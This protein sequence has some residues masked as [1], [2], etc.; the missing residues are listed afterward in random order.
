M[1]K[2]DSSLLQSDPVAFNQGTFTMFGL[3]VSENLKKRP[4]TTK[5]QSTFS[6][7]F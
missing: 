7:R 2:S 4:R 5:N 6:L 1:K 3:S